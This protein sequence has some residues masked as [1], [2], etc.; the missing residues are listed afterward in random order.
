MING[1]MLT[2]FQKADFRF[3]GNAK[4]THL[5]SKA[6]NSSPVKP[7]GLNYTEYIVKYH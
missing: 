5:I 4:H 6:E 2:S 3:R 7:Q 1:T